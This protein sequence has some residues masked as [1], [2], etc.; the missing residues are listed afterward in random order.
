VNKKQQSIVDLKRVETLE[1]GELK[2]S[3]Y[4]DDFPFPFYILVRQVESLPQIVASALQEWI[5]M[6]NPSRLDSL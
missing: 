1:N 4:M 6:M 5:E 2:I 3:S